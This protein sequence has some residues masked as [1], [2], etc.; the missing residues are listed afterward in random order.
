[1]TKDE[2]LEKLQLVG[3]VDYIGKE[4]FITEKYKTLLLLDENSIRILD[5]PVKEPLN[6]DKLLDASTNG[7]EWPSQIIDATGR[8][9]ATALMDECKI[10][11]SPKGQTYRLRGLD[12]ECVN[13]LGNIVS[14]K[15]IDP[16]TFI[17]VIKLY[18]KHTERPKAFKTL[19]KDG[20][21]LDMYQEHIKGDFRKSLNEGSGNSGTQKWN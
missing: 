9:R 14:N 8:T 4:Y 18:Y 17:D 19:I 2:I 21:V 16:S 5:A 3:I 13:I 1:M 10:P 6:Y 7:K 15:D 11:I 12:K 20:E